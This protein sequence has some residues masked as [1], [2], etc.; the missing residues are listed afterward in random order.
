MTSGQAKQMRQLFQ[1]LR[2]HG[3]KVKQAK[4]SHWWI[5]PPEDKNTDEIYFASAT[6]QDW[7]TVH[8]V[9]AWARRVG[10]LPHNA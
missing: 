4:N 1:V 2:D 10:G 8:N 6:P 5:Y 7:R 3:F 9:K